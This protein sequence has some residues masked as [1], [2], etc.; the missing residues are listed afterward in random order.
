MPGSKR[1]NPSL[2]SAAGLGQRLQTKRVSDSILKVKSA[3]VA[4]ISKCIKAVG[5]A[6]QDSSLTEHHRAKPWH[7]MRLH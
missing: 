5:G 2:A 3:S 1:T 7:L 6:K 4:I